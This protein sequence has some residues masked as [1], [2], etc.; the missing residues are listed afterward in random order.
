MLQKQEI[1][2][3]KE[4]DGKFPPQPDGM[5]G[6]RVSEQAMADAENVAGGRPMSWLHVIYHT[7]YHL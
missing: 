1:L 2:V 3:E 4:E 5:R 7:V 6:L